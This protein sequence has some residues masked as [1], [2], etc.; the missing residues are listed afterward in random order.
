MKR[1]PRPTSSRR[2]N[3]CSDD[4]KDARAPSF[5]HAREIPAGLNGPVFV[6]G[7]ASETG[8]R[9]ALFIDA[10]RRPRYTRAKRLKDGSVA[11]YWAIPTWA[12][13]QG[14]PLPP[15]ALGQD[16]QDAFIAAEQLNLDFDRWRKRRKLQV[17]TP[18]PTR[19][20]RSSGDRARPSWQP[21][22]ALAELTRAPAP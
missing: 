17:S 8:V 2:P 22:A 5:R 21:L 13:R 7:Q 9:P 11:Y 12:K 15:R 16:W 3:V 6:L 4:D 14:C 18:I 1:S 19:V 20:A 10:K